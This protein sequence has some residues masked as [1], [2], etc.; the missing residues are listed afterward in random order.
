MKKF[1]KQLLFFLLLAVLPFGF[2]QSTKAI[3][4][5]PDKYFLELNGQ[6]TEEKSLF[7]YGRENLENVQRVFLYTVGMKKVGEANNRDFY[8]VDPNDMTQVANWIDLEKTEVLLKKGDVIEVKWKISKKGDA[9]CGTN[10]A[11]IVAATAPLNNIVDG[12]QV[13]IK[14]EVISQVH[15]DILTDSNGQAC[16]ISTSKSKLIEF[17]V[18]NY[19]NIFGYQAVPFLTR[20]ENT[21]SYIVREPKGFIEIYQGG[22]KIES[23]PFNSEGL[24]IYPKT[25]RKFDN[26]WTD[27]DFPKDGNYFEQLWYEINHFK[28]G[29]YE[30]KLGVTKNISPQI[31][32]TAD[33]WIIPW[34]TIL[35]VIVIIL[36]ILLIYSI[37]RLS[38]RNSKKLN[39]EHKIR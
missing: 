2:I 9:Q 36:F 28:I 14:N 37:R 27:K 5:G 12:T 23:I 30:A 16:D 39:S 20:I 31:V 13:N 8:K 22:K 26:D 25:I 33:F 6:D 29:K 7:I 17:K 3:P 21:S 32:S 10:L 1:L 18:N 35:A 4:I 38:S 19:W 15:V 11:A 24:D 34:R